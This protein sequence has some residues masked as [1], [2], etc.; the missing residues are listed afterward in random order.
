MEDIKPIVKQYILDELLP[1]E[2]P[3]Q[4][5][6]PVQLVKGGILDSIATL[7]LVS[8]LEERFGVEMQAHEINLDNFNTLPEIEAIVQRKLKPQ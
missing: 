8:F 7:K 5:T 4:L 6:D 3:A 2:D 1:G